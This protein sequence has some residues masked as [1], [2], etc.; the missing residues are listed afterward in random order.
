MMS[1]D[2]SNKTVWDMP[3]FFDEEVTPNLIGD[4]IDYYL[5]D[6]ERLERIKIQEYVAKITQSET[7]SH[8]KA[9]SRRTKALRD[10]PPSLPFTKS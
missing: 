10:M 3:R 1:F 2:T 8:D 5:D 4:V 9:K 7:A 6:R